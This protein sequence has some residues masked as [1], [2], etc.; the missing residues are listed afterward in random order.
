VAVALEEPHADLPLEQADLLAERRL[1]NEEAFRGA[2]EREVLCHGYKVFQ[3]SCLHIAF[4]CY[5]KNLLHSK[6]NNTSS[7]LLD[8]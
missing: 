1:G 6:N 7:L 5:K 4:P 2:R 8:V 3:L